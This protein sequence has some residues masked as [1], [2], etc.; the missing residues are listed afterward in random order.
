MFIIVTVITSS[1]EGNRAGSLVF[2][3]VTVITSWG[4]EIEWIAFCLS[5]SQ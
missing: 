1:S 4:G 2:I 3:I 5:L